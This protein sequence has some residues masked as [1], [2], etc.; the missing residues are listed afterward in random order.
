MFK[1]SKFM[2][3]F[4]ML[5]CG[6][7]S[8]SS[9]ASA[10]ETKQFVIGDTLTFGSYEQDNNNSNGKE[11]IE[12]IVLDK[13]GNELLLIS[14]YCIENRIYDT[15]PFP[16]VFFKT[17]TWE[18]CILRKWLNSDFISY[19][20]NSD[21]REK[22]LRKRI[23]N[24]DNPKYNT[25]GGNDT[26]DKVFLLSI[27][28]AIRYFPSNAARRAAPTSYAVNQGAELKNGFCRWWLRSPGYFKCDAAH[29]DSDG[30]MSYAG[31]EPHVGFISVRPALWLDISK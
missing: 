18:R 26:E 28:E 24:F 31:A 4:L 27:N 25:D 7:L 5:L 15:L 3:A 29:V 1:K 20:F 2:A 13:K 9:I 10:D 30:G 14:K 22:I 17:V 16:A 23:K 11:P 8:L 12:W 6:L 21:D 19:A